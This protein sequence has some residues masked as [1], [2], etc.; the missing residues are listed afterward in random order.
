VTSAATGVDGTWQDARGPGA[1]MTVASNDRSRLL[2]TD[3]GGTRRG[4]S[5]PMVNHYG[6]LLLGLVATV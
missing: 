2:P 3:G 6:N 4:S 5:P 1:T